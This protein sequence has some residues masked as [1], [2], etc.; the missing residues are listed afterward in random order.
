[1][2]QP[3]LEPLFECSSLDSLTNPE[4]AEAKSEKVGEPQTEEYVNM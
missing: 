4:A 1:M 2:S 3:S